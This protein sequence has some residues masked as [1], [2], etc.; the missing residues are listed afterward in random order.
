MT[1][2][3][4]PDA[5]E[6][7]PINPPFVHSHQ[8]AS[9]PAGRPFEWAENAG[10]VTVMLRLRAGSTPGFSGSLCPDGEGQ[11]GTCHPSLKR[12]G[13]S[14]GHRPEPAGTRHPAREPDAE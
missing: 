7:P 14:V 13:S 9:V 10:A 6:R 4:G 1:P 3:E 5:G 2:D 11:S 12:G 8:P